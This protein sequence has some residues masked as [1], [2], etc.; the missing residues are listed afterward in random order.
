[1]GEAKA[2]GAALAAYRTTAGTVDRAVTAIMTE[3]ARDGDYGAVLAGVMHAVARHT[4]PR[5][6]PVTSREAGSL[7]SVALHH[8]LQVELAVLR[9]QEAGAPQT[10]R[11]CGCQQLAACVDARTGLTCYWVEPDLCSACATPANPH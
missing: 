4:L 5:V 3:F 11:V 8:A 10:C 6:E 9:A 1:M 7:V 2:K